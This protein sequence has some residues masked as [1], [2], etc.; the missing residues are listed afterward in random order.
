[1]PC[2]AGRRAG[3]DVVLDI[4]YTNTE[5]EAVT[6]IY[7]ADRAKVDGILFNPGGLPACRP[8]PARLPEVDPRAGAS[9][10]T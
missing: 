9:R 8:R 3:L 1:M 5:G 10:S 7:K 4:L 6:A 2:C